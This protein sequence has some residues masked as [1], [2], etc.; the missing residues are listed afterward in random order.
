VPELVAAVPETFGAGDVHY[1]KV[2]DPWIMYLIVQNNE[3]EVK[4]DGEYSY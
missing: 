3:Q 4:V 2:F 1:S